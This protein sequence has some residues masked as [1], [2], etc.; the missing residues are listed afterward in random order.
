MFY[1]A[2]SLLLQT[3]DISEGPCIL[4]VVLSYPL[5]PGEKAQQ[6]RVQTV[7][8]VPKT[9]VTPAPAGSSMLFGPSKA[10]SDMHTQ[11]KIQI[12]P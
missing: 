5:R 2:L 3:P 1:P 4:T 10:L 6:L 9:T 7:P 12:K 11:C 8:T